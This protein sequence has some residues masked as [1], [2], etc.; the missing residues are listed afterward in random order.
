ML[1][2]KIK[3]IFLGFVVSMVYTESHSFKFS[4]ESA[5]A[6]DWTEK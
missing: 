5:L 3:A 1:P 2:A 6:Q 4:F